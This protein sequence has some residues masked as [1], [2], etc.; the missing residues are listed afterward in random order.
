VIALGI[1]M[2]ILSVLMVGYGNALKES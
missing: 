1:G 2:I